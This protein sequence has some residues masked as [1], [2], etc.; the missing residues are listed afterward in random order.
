[1]DWL[2]LHISGVMQYL[3]CGWQWYER[4]GPAGRP[5][6]PGVAALIG[7][8]ADASVNL[9]LGEKLEHGILLPTEAVQ[10]NARDAFVR[11]WDGTKDIADGPLLT[12][13]ERQ[14]GVKSVQAEGIDTTVKLAV[15]HHDKLAPIIMPAKIQHQWVLEIPDHKIRLAGTLDLQ[16]KP[17]PM[18]KAGKV[19]DT[20]TAK[21][22]KIDNYWEQLTI[23]AMA[24]WKEDGEIPDLCIDWLLKKKQPEAIQE[25]TQRSLKD[26]QALLNKLSAVADGIRKGV[27]LPTGRGSWSCSERFCGFFPCKFV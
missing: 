7:T 8:G 5:M 4:N 3:R 2:T 9:D 20:K 6:P 16:E 12:K 1:M 25:N 22:A 23:Y 11:A 26:F 21:M 18:R 19:H 10:D 24:M 27:F 13:E 15:V 17:L 14:K